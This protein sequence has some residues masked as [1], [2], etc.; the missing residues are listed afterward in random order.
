VPALLVDAAARG[1]VAH[2]LVASA[3]DPC[4]APAGW[5]LVTSVVLGAR[6]AEP[7][8]LLDK[9]A[10]PQLTELHGDAADDWELLAAHHD[11]MA[12][13]AAPPP[14]GGA[15][16]VRLLDG[17]YVCGDHRDA[18]GLPGALASGRRAA[19]ALLADAGLRAPAALAA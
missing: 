19:E 4:L 10:R 15:R 1:P 18:P 17:L 7:P 3:A 6:A 14:Y 8:E 2:T 11:P 16:R 5:R 13:P 9:A 12:V